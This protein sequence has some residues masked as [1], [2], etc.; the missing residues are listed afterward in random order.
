MREPRF[1]AN[2]LIEIDGK[3]THLYKVYI[4]FHI[5]CFAVVFGVLNLAEITLRD[6]LCGFIK[7]GEKTLAGDV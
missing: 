4:A 3:E 5:A 2:D 1:F 7:T 6:R